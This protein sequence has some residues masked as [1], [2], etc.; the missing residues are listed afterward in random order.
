MH[1][2]SSVNYDSIAI[3]HFPRLR[4]D[5]ILQHNIIAQHLNNT[6]GCTQLLYISTCLFCSN[7]IHYIFSLFKLVNIHFQVLV[8]T[9]VL[10]KLHY[11]IIMKKAKKATDCKCTLKRTLAGILPF[12]VIPNKKSTSPMN[13]RKKQLFAKCMNSC[14]I[15]LQ[16]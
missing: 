10:N 2:Q 5:S 7:I 15:K 12:L 6:S 1:E 8:T 16:T 11:Y 9:V 13:S 14:A 3:V 4:T